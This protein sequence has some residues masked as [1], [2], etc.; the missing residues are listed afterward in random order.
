M[1]PGFKERME[2]EINNLVPVG[3]LVE[4]RVHPEAQY[5]AWLGGTIFAS[6]SVFQETLIKKQE[7]EENGPS[8]V[9]KKCII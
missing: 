9:H 7:Y 5:A 8:I 2:K 4:T 1:F 3:T 6:L